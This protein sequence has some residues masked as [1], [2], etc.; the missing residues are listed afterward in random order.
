VKA[1][2]VAMQAL[3]VADDDFRLLGRTCTTLENMAA[4]ETANVWIALGTG[5]AEPGLLDGGGR[6]G[7]VASATF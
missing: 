1:V 5:G 3:A 4:D 2:I 7:S 6:G